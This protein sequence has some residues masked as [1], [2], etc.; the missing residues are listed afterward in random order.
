MGTYAT[1]TALSPD[2]LW[3]IG[4]LIQDQLLAKH[5]WPMASALSMALVVVVATVVFLTRSLMSNKV[6][7]HG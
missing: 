4:Y 2:T 5:N 3:T 1:P 7:I 6:R